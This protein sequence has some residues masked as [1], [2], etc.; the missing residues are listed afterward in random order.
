[1]KEA[2]RFMLEQVKKLDR[3]LL[4]VCATPN[5][6]QIPAEI[7]EKADALFW[8]GLGGYDFS[9]YAIGLHAI[10]NSSRNAEVFV[11]NDSVFGPFC[12]LSPLLKCAQWDLTGFTGSTQIENHIQSYA[13][14]LK[15]L[16]KERLYHLRSIFPLSFSYDDIIPV[17]YCFETRFARIASRWMSVGS[18]F[19]GP[20]GQDPS[21]AHAFT[22]LDQGLPFLKKSLLGK[23]RDKQDERLVRAALLN[24]GFPASELN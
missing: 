4:I 6:D 18:F 15:N 17:I 10:V 12:N 22:L 21:L 23:H 5:P 7:H 2:Q 14:L 20:Q 19:F 24:L 8:K 3:R 16:T 1:M 13:F 11:L 9:A